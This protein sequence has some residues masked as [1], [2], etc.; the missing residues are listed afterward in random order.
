[1]MKPVIQRANQVSQSKNQVSQ[2]TNQVSQS[3]NEVSQ[4]ANAVLHENPVCQSATLDFVISATI[5]IPQVCMTD[6]DR[7]PILNIVKNYF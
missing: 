3:A 2:S 4:S 1:M 6:P 5:R 7:I